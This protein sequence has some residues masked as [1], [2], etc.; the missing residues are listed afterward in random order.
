MWSEP[1]LW[2]ERLAE[3]LSGLSE[4]TASGPC[5]IKAFLFGWVWAFSNTK[6]EAWDQRPTALL[7][8]YT[9]ALCFGEEEG[10]AVLFL[11]QP[12]QPS[13]HPASFPFCNGGAWG[14]EKARS[15]V[16]GGV[17][18]S[19]DTGAAVP[20]EQGEW[21]AV[22]RRLTHTKWGTILLKEAS[23]SP[24]PL[25]VLWLVFPVPWAQ[26]S[27]K[28]MLLQNMLHNSHSSAVACK[29]PSPNAFT[30]FLAQVCSNT[31]VLD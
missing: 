7:C 20:G 19:S 26:E 21:K 25:V 10:I 29:H 9:W 27:E 31:A 30:S 15:G 13:L 5:C 18:G 12:F 2:K 28:A 24:A 8:L 14:S 11:K 4:D 22:L 17:M 23:A 3:G 6:D 16:L 1:Q